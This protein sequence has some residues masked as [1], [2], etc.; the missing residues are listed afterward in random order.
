M[1]I[2]MALL[3]NRTEDGQA[4]RRLRVHGANVPDR[5]VIVDRRFVAVEDATA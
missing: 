5:W 2:G 3:I 1:P 4:V